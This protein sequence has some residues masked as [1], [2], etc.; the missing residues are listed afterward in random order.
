MARH[1]LTAPVPATDEHALTAAG[2]VLAVIYSGIVVIV[3]DGVTAHGILRAVG[4]TA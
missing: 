1:R 3:V 2:I 4:L